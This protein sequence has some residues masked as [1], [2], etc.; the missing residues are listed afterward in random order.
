MVSYV[1]GYPVYKTLWNHLTGKFLPS[2]REPENPMD[3]YT[4]CVK[5]ENKI[6]GYLPL[7]KSGKFVKTIFYFPKTDELS[8]C[9]IVVTEKPV[10]LGDAEGMQVSCKLIFT[11]IEKC[12]DILKRPLYTC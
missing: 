4:V 10:N 3:K 11:G 6:V 8:S 2:A 12:I 5:K 7:G 1:E 9:K